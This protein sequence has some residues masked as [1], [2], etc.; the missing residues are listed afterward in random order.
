MSAP[1]VSK[2]LEPST[3]AQTLSWKDQVT[4]SIPAG[5]LDGKQTLAIAPAQAVSPPTFKGIG[6]MAAYTV[7]LGNLQ[8]FKKPLTIEI[9]YDP[10]KLP[11]D[12]APQKALFASFWDPEQK[13]WVYSPVTVDTQR[14]VVVIKTDHLTTW[15]VYYILQG[16]GV[17]ES[18]HF[19]VVY[20][21]QVIP[22]VSGK[23]VSA[24]SFSNDVSGYLEQAYAAYAPATNK[25]GF[26]MPGGQTHAFVVPGTEESQRGGLTGNV[27]FALTQDSAQ[28]F[29]H[30]AAHESF[31]V[32]QNQYFNVYGMGWRKWWIEAT[33]DYAAY[34]EV[35]KGKTE[36]SP[37]NFT[38]FNKSITASDGKHEYQTA[39]FVAFLVKSGMSFREAWDAVAEDGRVN[40]LRPLETYVQTKT[41]ASLQNHFRN[42]VRYA[43]FDPAGPLEK[44]SKD[45]LYS[46][47]I[48]KPDILDAD[49]KEATYTFNLKPDYTAAIWGL[50]VQ[51]KDDK[52]ERPLHMEITGT[53]PPATQVQ[54]DVYLLKNDVRPQGGTT[55]R[56]TLDAS[57]AKFDLR[58]VKDDVVYIVAVNSSGSNQS[59]TVKVTEGAT[60][61]WV[62]RET[63]QKLTPPAPT[64]SDSLSK[65][66]AIS[67]QSAT[68]LLSYDVASG[69][70]NKSNWTCGWPAF[71]E[72]LTPGQELKGTVSVNSAGAS[73]VAGTSVFAS[74]SLQLNPPV[75]G[76]ERRSDAWASARVPDKPNSK[77]D[78]SWEIPGPPNEQLTIS[79]RCSPGGNRGDNTGVI[80]FVID[81][82]VQYKYEFRK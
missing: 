29:M 47:V 65:S 43:L 41:K 35:W 6:E 74:V 14:K 11:G 75:P 64:T 80:M 81:A 2:V 38:Y 18:Y 24:L 36:L 42:F 28:A 8:E 27:Y 66:A 55:A 19:L 40:V 5:L 25:P 32:V 9:A 44:S 12:L 34:Q 76:A 10:T 16:Y 20:D 63:I 37:L 67:G 49:K 79:V 71:P 52:T 4:V 72:K 17:K 23:Q 21:K 57:N 30:E 58:V 31:H 78:F 45:L 7:T 60:G 50:R 82:Y 68:V 26:R 62:L 73:A 61:T 13:L 69:T 22:I 53:P 1:L 51:A 56:G 33:A 46:G 48:D 70:Y 77:S 3:S 54:A 39:N 59:L 15:K